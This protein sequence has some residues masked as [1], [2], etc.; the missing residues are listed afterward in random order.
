MRGELRTLDH[1]ILL[2][3]GNGLFPEGFRKRSACATTSVP[4]G[5]PIVCGRV[6]IKATQSEMFAELCLRRSR[7]RRNIAIIIDGYN[8]DGFAVLGGEE[9]ALPLIT[10][11][12]LREEQRSRSTR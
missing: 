1:L 4:A 11:N 8:F 2:A 6:Y 12:S 9:L 3:E 5:R 10:P 7:R